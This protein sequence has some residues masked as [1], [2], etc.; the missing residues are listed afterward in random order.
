MAIVA[1][2]K[3]ANIDAVVAQWRQRCL[4]NEGSLLFDGEK[5]WTVENLTRLHDNVVGSPLADSRSFIEKFQVQL[6][7]DRQLVL[8]GAEAM[9]AY[10]L[11]VWRGGVGP[12]TKRARVNEILGWAG[13]SL[14]EDSDV[15]RALGEDGIGHPG[16]FYLL[17]PDAQLGFLTDFVRRF[18]DL[19]TQERT[20][21]ADDP[22]KLRDFMGAAT[23][24]SVPGIRHVLLHLLHPD[25]YERI[26][27]GAHKANIASTYAS[28][29]PDPEIEDLDERLLAIRMRL[30]DLIGVAAEDLDFYGPPLWGTW[31]SG[32][33]T[34]GTD[35][36]SA[37]RLKR[38]LVFFG[39][40]GTSKTFEAKQLAE[41]IIR[42]AAIQQW[43][44]VSYF[45]RLGEVDDAIASHIRRLQLHPAYSYEEFIRGLRLRDGRTQ[46]ENGYLLRLVD[47]IKAARQD[48]QST[49]PWVLIL[50]EFNRADL[51]RVFGEAFSVLEDRD[52]A[53][54]LPGAEPGEQTATLSLP[55]DLYVIG[56][57]NLID[58]SLEQVDFAL[59]RRFL[60]VRSGFDPQRLADVLPQL[61]GKTETAG[62]Y[63]WSRIEEDAELF[64]A[65]AEML[66]EHIADSAM[67]GRDYEIGHT[68]FFDVVGLLSRADHLHRKH[69][70]RRYLWSAKREA[71]QPVIDLWTMSLE[72]L[73]DQYLQG[74][75][76]DARRAELDRLRRVF[77]K[78]E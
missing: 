11:F 48:Q 56:T 52:S 35:P 37:I 9:V 46:Y 65:R 17:R 26:A 77:L 57:M 73:L 75:D 21:T 44:A 66:N 4:L 70:P 53:V 64:K 49:L 36:L 67:L 34:D 6:G 69:R 27:S 5:V 29:V 33:A 58:Q 14:A 61:W 62:R 41:R 38:Q 45:E 7:T 2:T 74:V 32:L 40:P 43:G 78:G 20:D 60:W 30:Q 1:G 42:Q 68:Y 55:A 18:K 28:L 72:P 47:E 3:R 22:W 10:Y 51:S 63:S 76:A 31:A 12:R 59:R 23:D 8:L 71:L 54:E 16:Q 39:P 24:D 25:A 19:S 50:D 13:E 15:W